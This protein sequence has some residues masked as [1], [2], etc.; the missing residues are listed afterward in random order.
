MNEESEERGSPAGEPSPVLIGLACLLVV[1]MV[2]GLY[3]VVPRVA[4]RAGLG[5]NQALRDKLRQKL[6]FHLVKD[7]AAGPVQLE[8]VDHATEIVLLEPASGTYPQRFYKLQKEPALLGEH[9]LD[10]GFDQDE[11]GAPLI[12]MT[13]D[14]IGAK[15][16]ENCTGNHVGEHLA[17]F[18]ADRVT[19]APVIQSRISGGRVQITGHHLGLI[20]ESLLQPVQELLDDESVVTEDIVLPEEETDLGPATA[21]SP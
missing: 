13:F 3:V 4:G 19:S 1:A 18:F 7:Q 6:R 20:R 14:D 15:H 2:A 11:L 16:L 17:I 21:T 10:A 8:P 9:I 12:F 5:R